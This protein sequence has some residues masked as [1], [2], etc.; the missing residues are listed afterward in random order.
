M[1]HVGG[2]PAHNDL[3]AK[4]VTATRSWSGSTAATSGANAESDSR[5]TVNYWDPVGYVDF[6]YDLQRDR[7]LSP[8]LTDEVLSYAKLSPQSGTVE[9]ANALVAKIPGGPYPQKHGWIPRRG[10]M[11]RKRMAP[12]TVRQSLPLLTGAR[13]P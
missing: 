3:S 1:L 9:Y 7:L 8:A 13:T 4:Y 6:L 5:Y 11:G 12:I 2:L 10:P